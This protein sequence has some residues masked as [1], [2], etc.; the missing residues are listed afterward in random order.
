MRDAILTLLLEAGEKDISGEKICEQLGVTRAAVWKHIKALREDGFEIA[1][2]TRR[3]YRLLSMPDHLEPALIRHA[4]GTREMGQAIQVYDSCDS[5]NL[6]AKEWA[7]QGAPNGALV[8]AETQTAGRGR[9]GR[10]WN[11]AKG[12]GLFMSVVLRPPFEAQRAPILTMLSAAAVSA[13][14]EEVCKV[15][16]LIK[17]PNDVIVN[18]KKVCGILAEMSADMDNVQWVVMGIGINV[19][20]RIEDFPEEIR[21]KATSLLIETGRSFQRCAL[22]GAVMRQMEQR[23]DQLMDAGE[24]AVVDY[25]RR[26]SATLGQEVLLVTREGSRKARAVDLADDGEL[27]VENEQGQRE[28]V[29]SGEVSVRGILGYV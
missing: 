26:H 8:L 6:R 7:A 14:L 15:Q 22:A 12:Q 3:G 28:K 19:G 11:S 17:W 23:Y 13:A 10:G 21:D 1:S 2:A 20:Q 27:I 25:C 4:A 24:G 18:G 9:L 5:T 16:A 29:V